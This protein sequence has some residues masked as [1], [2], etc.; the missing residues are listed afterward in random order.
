MYISD[1]KKRVLDAFVPVRSPSV[2]AV[3]SSAYSLAVHHDSRLP[4]LLLIRGALICY[5]L[6]TAA[7]LSLGRVRHVGLQ[8]L[9][10]WADE[11]KSEDN[12][13]NIRQSSRS[14]TLPL[15]SLHHHVTLSHSP[16]DAAF[17]RSR[18]ACMNGNNNKKSQNNLGRA[19][20]P[21]HILPIGCISAKNA[22][23]A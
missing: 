4:A 23:P 17:F 6:F 1:R 5:S 21:D 3:V 8:V 18:S 14:L 10:R 11:N 16:D 13:P 9:G 2:Q 7:D 20:S 12:L 22:P 15:S 19:A